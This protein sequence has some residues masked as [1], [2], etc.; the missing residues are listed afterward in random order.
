MP[1]PRQST[2]RP[3]VLIGIP[4]L[5]LVLLASCVFV[6]K[7]YIYLP[8]GPYR[9]V[10]ELEYNPVVPNPKGAP[11][12]EKV[13]LEFDEITGG[14]LPF[15]FDV[16]YDTDTTFH[17][18]IHNGEEKITVP[19]KDISTGRDQQAGRDTIRI[20]FPVYDTHISAY[21]EENVIE[22][23]WVVHYRDNYRIPFK[24]Y[25]GKGYRFTPLRKQPAADLSGQ[26]AVTF[27]GDASEDPYP[28]VAEF[29]QEGNRL[30]GTIRTETGDYRYLEGTV[31]AN[32]LY[33][34][35]FDGSHAFLFEALIKDDGS[36]TGTFRS[37]RHYIT[38]W[39]A[40]RSDT[41]ELTDPDQLTR[42]RDEVPLAF[43]FPD[44]NGDT[45]R[46][47]DFPGPKLIQL[48]GTWCPNCR[49]ETNFI[50]EYLAEHD[51]EDL[52]VVALAFERYGATDERSRAAVRRYIEN[53]E[54]Q[55]PVLLAGSNDKNEAG[56]A[57]P[58][59]NKVISYPT[60]LFVDRDNRVRR[61]H[62]GFNGPATSKYAEFTE[63]FDRTIKE[64]LADSVPAQ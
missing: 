50:Q 21:H 57:L 42:L 59:L 38:D 54:V 1:A 62:T 10:L 32:K 56:R 3:A 26:W 53:Q 60:L 41:A 27:A 55:W 25:F 45:L 30:T 35:V 24:A 13:G 37:G 16:V 39:T 44:P 58:M 15:N 17:L 48:F 14:Q 33:L 23:V 52:Q 61:I 2:P 19:A 22:G 46:L 49:D 6:Q 31:Q 36:L 29:R 5:L 40:A 4:A 12:P 64:L 18:V 47:S 7:R 63:S 28:G 9:G 8:P 11:I 43:A 51:T 34:S 20:D